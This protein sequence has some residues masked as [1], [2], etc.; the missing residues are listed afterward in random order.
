LLLA[1]TLLRHVEDHGRRISIDNR[2]MDPVTRI[3][4]DCQISSREPIDCCIVLQ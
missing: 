2:T 3:E 1:F 4:E